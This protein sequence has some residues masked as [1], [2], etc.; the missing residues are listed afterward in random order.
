MQRDTSNKDQSTV[1]TTT[2]T[3]NEK[4]TASTASTAVD[5]RMCYRSEC[6][7][8]LN[9]NTKIKITKIELDIKT[10][11]STLNLTMSP[12]GAM[13]ELLQMGKWSKSINDE[14]EQQKTHPWSNGIV[15]VSKLSMKQRRDQ[16]TKTS[17]VD[18]DEM[19]LSKSPITRMNAKHMSFHDGAICYN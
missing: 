19:D 6:F 17:V 3:A 5:E 9:N 15:D 7:V 8:I 18:K 2:T 1:T 11:L 16:Q 13:L 14:N 4:T 12:H 10:E